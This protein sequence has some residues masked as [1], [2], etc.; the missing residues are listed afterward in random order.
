MVDRNALQNQKRK[1]IIKV[2]AKTLKIAR[3][4][5]DKNNF[6]EVQGP[7]LMPA[8]GDW[9]NSFQVKYFDKKAY[10]SQGLQ[11]YSFT[12]LKMFKKIYTIAPTF[13]SEK[14][15]TKRHLTEYWRIESAASHY[16]LNNIIKIQEK[17]VE[18]ICRSLSEDAV[19]ELKL[20]QRPIEEMIQI[21]APFPRLTYDQTIELLQKE[22]QNINWGE[23]LSWELREKA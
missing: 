22:G 16:N 17:M 19:E 14:L 13:R 4:W 2:R 20:L 10:L 6:T 1:A 9:P 12:F 18:R 11:P 8:F 3:S 7:V 15:R 23:D 21:R 5:F